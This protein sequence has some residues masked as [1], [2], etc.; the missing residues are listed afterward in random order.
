MTPYRNF[1]VRSVYG[2]GAGEVREIVVYARTAEE[3]EQIFL[4]DVMDNWPWLHNVMAQC[5]EVEAFDDE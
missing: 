1:T 4:D 2:D 5:L 3:A